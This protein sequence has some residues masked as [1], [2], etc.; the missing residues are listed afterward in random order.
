M[1]GQCFP[2]PTPI[3]GE[4]NKKLSHERKKILPLPCLKTPIPSLSIPLNAPEST[5]SFGENVCSSFMQSHMY[6]NT[7]HPISPICFHATTKP[8]DNVCE[9]KKKKICMCTRRP[10]W[11]IVFFPPFVDSFQGKISFSLEIYANPLRLESHL[12]LAPFHSAAYVVIDTIFV[13]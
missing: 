5:N 7:I 13:W 8:R 6:I 9:K 10:K 4:M 1:L 2:L 11:K 12:C 3:N